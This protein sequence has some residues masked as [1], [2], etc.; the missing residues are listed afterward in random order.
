MLGVQS[1]IVGQ[2]GTSRILVAGHG[3]ARASLLAAGNNPQLKRKER[4]NGKFSHRHRVVCIGQLGPRLPARAT[5]LG[6]G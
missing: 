3:G 6:K 2:T 4:G 5:W 1:V